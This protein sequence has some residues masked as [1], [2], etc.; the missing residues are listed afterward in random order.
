MPVEDVDRSVLDFDFEKLCSVS[1][2]HLNVYACLICGKYFQG[3]PI[4]RWRGRVRG[5]RRVD[6]AGRGQKTHAYTHSVDIDHRVFLNLSTLRFYCLP[7]NY[8]IIDSSLDDI[9]VTFSFFSASE[10]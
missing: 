9:K 8:E 1:L 3:A 5:R 10:E 7:D 6:W 4:A 2:S